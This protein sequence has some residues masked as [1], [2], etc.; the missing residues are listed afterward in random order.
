MGGT[1]NTGRMIKNIIEQKN[2]LAT[3]MAVSMGV[4]NTA[5]YAY[6]KRSSIQTSILIK[7]CHAAK[8][9]FFKDIANQFPNDYTQDATS[10][11]EQEIVALKK[12]IERLTYEN[13]LMR[14]LLKK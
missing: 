3:K 11:S 14:D 12:E 8:H 2:L 1:I 6:E 7:L 4:P 13:N 9:N 5:I 10:S